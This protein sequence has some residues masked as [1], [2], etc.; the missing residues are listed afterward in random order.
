MESMAK[1]LEECPEWFHSIEL[2]P[3]MITP[4]RKSPATLQQELKL[5]RLPDLRGKSV[6]DIGAYDGYFSFA[7]EKLGAS[8][9]V[10]L[11]HYVWSTDMAAYMNDWRE[12]KRTGQPLPPPHESRHWRPETMPG[13]KPF[14]LA[15]RA[16]GSHVEP[17]V[18]DFMTMDL[19]ELGEFDVVFFLG[20][21]YHLEDPFGA[22]RKLRSVTSPGGL[23]VI[24]TESMEIPLLGNRACCEFFPGLELN[25]DPSN[26]WSPNAR[27]IEGFCRA[28]GFRE[29]VAFRERAPSKLGRLRRSPLAA[30]VKG[31]SRGKFGLPTMRGRVFAHARG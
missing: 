13:R 26:W 19:G 6:L 23:A 1:I 20:I 7:A 24:E 21:L 4:G 17:I 11:D 10:A 2:E 25:N 28:A 15:R 31:C 5:M 27:A 29:T 12:S 9:V 22:V 16:L 30:Y 18:G 14:D 8:R 3:G